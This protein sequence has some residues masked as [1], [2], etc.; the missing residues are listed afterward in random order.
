MTIL[1]FIDNHFWA[2]WFLVAIIF[3]SLAEAGPLV[4]VN[5]IEHE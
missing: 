4:V 2:L 3:V 5:R 1:Q